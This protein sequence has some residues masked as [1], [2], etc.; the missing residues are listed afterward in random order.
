M[1]D[2]AG[3]RARIEIDMRQRRSVVLSAMKEMDRRLGRQSRAE[4]RRRVDLFTR[5]AARA[6]KRRCDE[7]YAGKLAIRRRLRQRVDQDRS[8]NRVADQDRVI[9]ERGDLL[10][11][12][13]LPYRMAG[14]CLVRHAR[15]ADVVTWP[16]LPPQTVDQ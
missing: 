13:G 16:E 6:H 2:R 5:P 9:V 12:R 1:H 4:V 14:V 15:I 10:R 11:E 8:A 3:Y 7:T